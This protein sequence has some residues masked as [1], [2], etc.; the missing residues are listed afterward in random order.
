MDFKEE[1]TKVWGEERKKL[2]EINPEQKELYKAQLV[3]IT[4]IE[5]V[6]AELERNELEIE[7]RAAIKDIDEQIASD[8]MEQEKKSSK[9][10]NI[11]EAVKIGAPLVAAF[12]MGLISMHWEK[13]DT[14][15]SSA[16]KSS[17]RDLLRFK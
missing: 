16:G 12:A 7:A 14:L 10:R 6:L 13:T 17:V 11:I 2:K 1:L 9:V 5:K 8:Q 4:D 3:R 15:T